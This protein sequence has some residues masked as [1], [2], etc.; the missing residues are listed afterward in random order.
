MCARRQFSAA[1][2]SVCTGAVLTPSL[3]KL[4]L[5]YMCFPAT[6]RGT[7]VVPGSEQQKKPRCAVAT[8]LEALLSCQL[9]SVLSTVFP[10]KCSVT[11]APKHTW[12]GKL[13]KWKSEPKKTSRRRTQNDEQYGEG[14]F[15][16]FTHQVWPQSSACCTEGGLLACIY[17]KLGALWLKFYFFPYSLWNEHF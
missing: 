9:S 5:L 13:L 2:S 16:L 11:T 1:V 17:Y 4:R 6:V 7:T 12:S 15:L 8:L 10:Q 3:R 14:F